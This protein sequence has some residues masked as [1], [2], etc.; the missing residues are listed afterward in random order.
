[1]LEKVKMGGGNRMVRSNISDTHEYFNR[2]D[3]ITSLV[4]DWNIIDDCE[5]QKRFHEKFPSSEIPRD[6]TELILSI[7]DRGS[8][9]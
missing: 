6:R 3:V 4:G 2:T 1:M 5:L 9:L 7:D 8:Y